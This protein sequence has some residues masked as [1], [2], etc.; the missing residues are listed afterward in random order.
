[1]YIVDGGKNID[2]PFGMRKPFT[3]MHHNPFSIVQHDI[4]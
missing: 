3:R 1:M 4:Y 2:T